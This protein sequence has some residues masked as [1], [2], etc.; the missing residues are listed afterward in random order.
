MLQDKLFYITTSKSI[1][2][3]YLLE[4]IKPY[5]K[6]TNI[7]FDKNGI[8]ISAKDRSDLSYTY[9]HLKQDNFE[10][11]NCESRYALGIDTVLFFKCIKS[12]GKNDTITFYMDK[13]DE[14]NLGVKL[15]EASGCKTKDYKL[16]V[17]V[18]ED[19]IFEITETKHDHIILMPS[20]LFQKIVKDIELVDGET[21]EITCVNKQIGFKSIDGSANVK[22]NLREV[23]NTVT[24]VENDKVIRFINSNDKIFVGTFKIAY[25]I[26]FI[27]AIHLSETMHIFL[28]NDRPLFL[29]YPISDLGTITFALQE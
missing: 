13:D 29:E 18:L 19:R 21:V 1:M 3:K 14:D 26:N 12:T 16:P 24:R 9:I 8:K 6:E 10:Y 2:I 27:K 4:V 22:I 7:V 23:A 5:I 15:T 20:S 25:L 11:F 28:T 17:M